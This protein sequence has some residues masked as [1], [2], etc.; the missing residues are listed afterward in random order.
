MWKVVNGHKTA[1][2]TYSPNGST[3]KG[4]RWWRYALSQY[5]EFFLHLP[6]DLWHNRRDVAAF[7]VAVDISAVWSSGL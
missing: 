4:V 2:A 6:P 7:I 3:G 1:A 5:F